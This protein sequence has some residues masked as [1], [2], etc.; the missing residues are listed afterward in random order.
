MNGKII[1]TTIVLF[2]AVSCSRYP[3]ELVSVFQSAENNRRELEKVLKHYGRHSSDNMKYR[4][5]EFLLTNMPGHFAYD[6]T[7][8]YLYDPIL[9]RMDSMRYY[10]IEGRIALDAAWDS[11]KRKYPLQK[12]V[13]RQQPDIKH[14]TAK[15]IIKHIDD[16]MVDSLFYRNR[17]FQNANYVVDFQF[18][19][20]NY[21]IWG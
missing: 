17:Y 14:I 7:E 9:Y 16:V 1:K 19:G 13:F 15:Y 8:L 11:L 5:T 2:L 3:P 4:A 12:H 20:Q 6:T 10:S 21:I 18:L